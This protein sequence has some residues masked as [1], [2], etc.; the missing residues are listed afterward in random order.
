M[1]KKKCGKGGLTDIDWKPVVMYT[2]FSSITGNQV[3]Q[4]LIMDINFQQLTSMRV[5]ITNFH[6][7]ERDIHF[8]DFLFLLF[9]KNHVNEYT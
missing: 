7:Y 3:L 4:G 6:S 8:R 9:C 2:P 5:L 1:K